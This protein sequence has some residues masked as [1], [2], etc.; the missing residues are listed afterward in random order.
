M[1]NQVVAE[2]SELQPLFG[3]YEQIVYHLWNYFSGSSDRR[4]LWNG[5]INKEDS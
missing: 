2:L 1:G 3:T 4:S 5:T